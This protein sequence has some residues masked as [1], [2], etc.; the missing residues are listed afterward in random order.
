[1][2]SFGLVSEKD[3]RNW[4]L[5]YYQEAAQDERPVWSMQ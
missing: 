4:D 3:I 5:S 1:M 2:Q